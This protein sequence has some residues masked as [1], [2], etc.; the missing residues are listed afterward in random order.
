V[1]RRMM[2]DAQLPQDIGGDFVAH[3]RLKVVTVEIDG[4]AIIYDEL[5][6]LAHLLSPTATIVW[7]SLDG[8]SRLR[9]VAV[10]LAEAFDVSAEQ[11][12]GDVLKLVRE[13]A[14][15][16]LLENVPSTSR[17]SISRS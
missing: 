17:R 10:G 15:R 2:A 3:R 6:E 1:P 4:E 8:Q 7:E 13:F 9:E 16:D 11:V 14:H 5:R 12:L